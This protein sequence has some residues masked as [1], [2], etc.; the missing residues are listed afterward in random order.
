MKSQKIE[1]LKLFFNLFH[2]K[3]NFFQIVLTADIDPL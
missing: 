1:K 3:I 2:K